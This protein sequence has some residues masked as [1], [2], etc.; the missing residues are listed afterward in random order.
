MLNMFYECETKHLINAVMDRIRQYK[1]KEARKNKIIKM[2]VHAKK[3]MKSDNF[4][5]K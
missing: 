3:K 2:L 4:N 1:S 5:K